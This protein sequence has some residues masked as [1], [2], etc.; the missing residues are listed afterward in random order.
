MGKKNGDII[1]IFDGDIYIYNIDI[2]ISSGKF[3]INGF[4]ETAEKSIC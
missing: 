1:R 2:W 3:D 4:L